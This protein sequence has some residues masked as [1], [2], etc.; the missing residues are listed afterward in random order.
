MCDFWANI[1]Y[2]AGTELM[3]GE[4]MM[5]GEAFRATGPPPPGL[6]PVSGGTIIVTESQQP[7]KAPV[8]DPVKTLI[9]E[10]DALANITDN[11][12]KPIPPATPKDGAPFAPPPPAGGAS[13][14]ATQIIAANDP[15]QASPPPP[16]TIAPVTDPVPEPEV[17]LRRPP[18]AEPLTQRTHT[19]LSFEELKVVNRLSALD[20]DVRAHEQ[21]H[22]AA[23]SGLAG[24][25]QYTYVTGPDAQRYAVSG[26]VQ[27]DN[28]PSPAS[29]QATIDK[30]EQVKKA[31]LAPAQPSGQD[32]AV[33]NA[34]EAT[35]REAQAEIRANEREEAEEAAAQDAAKKEAEARGDP[36]VPANIQQANLAFAQAGAVTTP[37]PIALQALFA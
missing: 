28:S 36:V 26:E 23:A 5:L 13:A 8:K 27:I 24:R 25:P 12:Y 3:M 7:T 14:I 29:P 37:A 10:S 15:P 34:A 16:A 33:A 22:V 30:M 1:C 17:S 9:P 6:V 4:I 18:P 19:Q 32:E 20:R 2:T 35:I 21:A 11:T 31:A